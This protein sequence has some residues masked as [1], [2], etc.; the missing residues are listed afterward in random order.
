VELFDPEGRRLYLTEGERAAFLD[1]ESK[2]SHG[3]RTLC[4][5]LHYTGCRVSEALALTPERVD[6]F[7]KVSVFVWEKGDGF[8]FEYPFLVCPA[9]CF[10]SAA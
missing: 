2:A 6:L 1:A 7:G 4:L 5:T 8:I 3:A 9:S 10:Q